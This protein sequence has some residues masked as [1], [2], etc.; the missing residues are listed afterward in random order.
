[1]VTQGAAAACWKSWSIINSTRA[2][3]P[4]PLLSAVT[5]RCLKAPLKLLRCHD[6]LKMTIFQRIVEWL[7]LWAKYTC[8]IVSCPVIPNLAYL[9]SFH[10]S[11][12]FYSDLVRSNIL[13]EFWEFF[14]C[15]A[16]GSGIC[17]GKL[18]VCYCKE[19]YDFCCGSF[20]FSCLLR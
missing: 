4:L 7:V 8:C 17:S 15:E 6:V 2:A 3:A 19:K 10:I 14:Q 9:V 11:S 16:N 5:T 12:A 1:M 13:R 18:W 20:S